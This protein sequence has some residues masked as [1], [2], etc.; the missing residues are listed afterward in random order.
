MSETQSP[1]D[2]RRCVDGSLAQMRELFAETPLQLN[3]HLSAR[4]GA[5][6]WLK[7]EDLSPVRS[8]KIRGAFNFIRKALAANPE[9]AG[10]FVCASA[11]NHAQ[12]L[13]YVCRHFG[14]K[15]VV[16]MPVTTPQQK[17]DKT[18]VF[19][20]EFIEIRLTGDFFDACYR[21]ALE[22]AAAE[23]ALMA[24][25]FDH[26][27]IIEGQASVGAEEKRS[28]PRAKRRILSCCRSAAAGCPAGW[29]AISRAGCDA[30]RFLLWNRTGRRA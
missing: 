8:Y 21:A 19:G 10:L 7:R 16:F 22:F 17:I 6:I 18:R 20:G 27:D 24:P 15:G 3:D 29:R 11:G 1:D 12:G 26:D 5:R 13:A 30:E 9:Q 28:C 2:F 14:R 23:G 4:F 25:P